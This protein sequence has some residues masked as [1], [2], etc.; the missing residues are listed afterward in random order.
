MRAYL[1][2][3][4][5]AFKSQFVYRLATFFKLVSSMLSLLVQ[6]SLWSSLINSGVK[7]EISMSE[8]LVYVI[9][10]AIVLSLTSINIANDL[11]PE[12]RD[13]T[14]AIYLVRP[15]SLHLY[16]LSVN[17][18]KTAFNTLAT[19]LPAVIISG[20]FIGIS[21]PIQKIYLLFFF[22][23]VGL[24]VFIMFE[25]TYIVGLLAFWV[26]RTWYLKWYLN[27][28]VVFLGGTV[29]PI[30]FYPEAMKNIS[31]I[32]PFRY[33]S[34]EAV[35]LYLEKTSIQHGILVIFIALFWVMVLYFCGRFMWYKIQRRIMIN[36]G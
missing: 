5:K 27:A 19:V 26:Q 4:N 10:N 25:L 24:G 31:Y 34:F 18:G 15:L 6:I 30:W 21:L 11:E 36:G 12:I 16:L 22:L 7:D 28:G 9:V 23:S 1:Y 13:G 29:V 14:I 2:L 8:M 17:F 32:L 33:I 20:L 3:F 35:N